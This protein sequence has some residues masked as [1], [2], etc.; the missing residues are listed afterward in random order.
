MDKLDDVPEI[1]TRERAPSRTI[2]K[3]WAQD[4]VHRSKLAQVA[5]QDFFEDPEHLDRVEQTRTIV[6]RFFNGAKTY[7]NQR[8]LG[9]APFTVLKVERPLFPNHLTR[10]QKE[11][12]LYGPLRALNVEIRFARGSDSY[13]FRIR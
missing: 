7:V 10:D 1:F 2:A 3:G 8:G 6:K 4:A 9:R 13:L 12:Q 11:A 5:H